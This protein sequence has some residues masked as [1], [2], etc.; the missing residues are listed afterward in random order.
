MHI[1]HLA[2]S[3]PGQFFDPSALQNLLLDHWNGGVGADLVYT[4]PLYQLETMTEEEMVALEG[5]KARTGGLLA[6]IQPATGAWF[7]QGG[8]R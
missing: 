3:P 4:D 6:R 1:L 7:K 5:L 2:S 8:N